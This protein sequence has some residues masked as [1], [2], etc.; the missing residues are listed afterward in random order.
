VVAGLAAAQQLVAGYSALIPTANDG[1]GNLVLVDVLRGKV[2]ADKLARGM[3]SLQV[4]VA[5][6][7]GNTR[8]NEFFLLDLFWTPP[9]A[10]NAGAVMTFELRDADN[11]LVAGGAR[12]SLFKYKWLDGNDLKARTFTSGTPCNENSA[13]CAN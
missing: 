1:S 4:S 5:G 11:R 7:G 12:T 13:L 10:F 6:A 8:V 9:P 2:L 3:P